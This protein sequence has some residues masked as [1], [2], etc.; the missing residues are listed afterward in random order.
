MKNPNAIRINFLKM[1]KISKLPFSYNIFNR[2]FI[3][4][5]KLYF[6]GQVSDADKILHR[7]E[8]LGAD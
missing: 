5:A 2:F 8:V 6:T 3:F 7:N 1:W 4:W